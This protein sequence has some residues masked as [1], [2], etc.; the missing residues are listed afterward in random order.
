MHN[1]MN[2]ITGVLK[3]KR[4]IKA[5]LG[6]EL[7]VKPDRI[8]AKERFGS[9]YGGWDLVCYGIDADSIVY[10]FGIGED[11]TFD[12][13]LIKKFNLVVHAFD[14][15]PRSISWIKSQGFSDHFVL[16]ELGLAAV[17]GEVLFNPPD[18]PEHISHTLLER[19][20]TR[21]KAIS[22]PV[23]RLS[24]IMRD[25]KHDRLDVLKMDI[26]GAEYDVI[27]DIYSSNIRPHQ[28]L[29]EF[30]HRFYKVGVGK[31]KAAIARIKSMG[32]SLFSVSESNEEYCFIRDHIRPR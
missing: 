25:L 30:H 20:S 16:H 6:K 22:V 10:S 23:K 28:I 29:I 24:T 32:Y 11:A 3:M 2:I 1:G 12:T 31:S 18:N 5:T 14:P 4:R 13:A 19:P 15:T 26:E 7:L 21:A 17:D 27:E 9:K 8:V